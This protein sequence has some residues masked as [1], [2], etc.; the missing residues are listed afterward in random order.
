MYCYSPNGYILKFKDQNHL[1]KVLFLTRKSKKFLILLFFT[2]LVGKLDKSPDPLVFLCWSRRIM[3][4][5][6]WLQLPLSE[7]L[8]A[9]WRIVGVCKNIDTD[10]LLCFRGPGTSPRN[11]SESSTLLPKSRFRKTFEEWDWDSELSELS[12]FCCVQL[13]GAVMMLR[14]VSCVKKIT[15]WLLTAASLFFRGIQNRRC[16]SWLLRL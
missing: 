15:A 16:C 5:R 11:S 14:S 3:F 2:I 4:T 8:W 1:I 13:N 9:D 7:L 12:V 6:T 10:C